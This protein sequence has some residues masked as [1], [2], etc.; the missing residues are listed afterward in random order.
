MET[1][2]INK[3]G[4]Y[5]DFS[6]PEIKL[7]NFHE[8]P[9]EYL[10]FLD[11]ISNL[12]VGTY[13]LY[14]YELKKLFSFIKEQFN[15][16]EIN[17]FKLEFITSFEQVI[18]QAID[19][20]KITRRIGISRIRRVQSFLKFLS[21]QNK[22]SFIYQHNIP[23]N[24][25][26]KNMRRF[27]NKNVPSKI[28]EFLKDLEN[29]NYS[30]V[31]YYQK[32]LLYYY[33]FLLQNNYL[34]DF[35]TD[36]IASENLERF[37]YYLDHKVNLENLE[38]SSALLYLRAIKLYI[39]YVNRGKVYKE[40]YTI[41]ERFRVKANRS[42]EYVPSQEIVRILQ[43]IS[44]HSKYPLRDISIALLVID[45]GCRP[46]EIIN[47]EMESVLISER[48][49][50]L[51]SKKSGQRKLKINPF[52][53]SYLYEYFKQRSRII[54]QHSALFLNKYNKPLNINA[55]NSIFYKANLR[56]YKASKY[57]PKALRH[58]YITNALDNNNSFEQVSK[59]VGHKHF[60]STLIYLERS[61]KRLLSNS[62]PHDPYEY[63]FK[64]E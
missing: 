41:P 23:I 9:V 58:S 22:I 42:N 8:F 3:Q 33:K 40:S 49:V 20:N 15:I 53:F 29:R 44:N 17:D 57:S 38:R 55:I 35:N 63:L 32:R 48:C 28:I 6:Q 19:T 61:T 50:L 16:T 59:A 31:N 54:G 21:T 24:A 25:K 5:D 36:Y 13:R 43:N 30:N 18:K 37:H 2:L 4:Y 11:S 39:E 52:A 26:D 10:D 12:K 64:E 1:N 45:T 46:I 62:L 47:M 60:V 51:K 56:L 7:N 27:E 34:S 14:F